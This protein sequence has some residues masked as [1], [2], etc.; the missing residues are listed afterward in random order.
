MENI[1]RLI[2]IDDNLNDAEMMISAIKSGGYA[3]RA[4][5]AEDEEDFVEALKA[6]SPDVVLLTLGTESIDLENTV[7]RIREAGKHIPVIAVSSDRSVDGVECMLQGAEDLVFKDNLEHLK[8]VVYRTF[9]SQ[10]QWRQLKKVEASLS[11][12]EKRCRIL[13]D[14]SRDSICYVHEG[15]HVYANDTY[16]NLFGYSDPDEIEGMP[17]MDMVAPDHQQTMKKF[18]RNLKKAAEENETLDIKLQHADGKTFSAQMEFSRASVDG[19]SCT[20]II[21]RDQTDAEEIQQKLNYLSQLDPTTRLFNRK[22]FMQQLE[23]AINRAKQGEENST[24]VQVDIC[25]IPEIK[26][27]VGVAHTDEVIADVAKILESYCDKQ[28]LLAKFGEDSFSILTAQSAP[29]K[30]ITQFEKMVSA[31]NNHVSNIEGRSV[32]PRVCAGAAQIDENTPDNNE[33]LLRVEKTIEQIKNKNLT[34]FA[35]YVP[36]EGEMTQKQ[37][38]SMWK[39][40]L[41]QAL[42]DGHFRLVFQPIVSLH[43]DPGERYEIYTRLLDDHNQEISASQFMPSVERTGIGTALDRW[44]I[45]NAINQLGEVRKT[46]TDTIFFVKLTVGSLQ[47]PD[48]LPW[49]AEHLRESFLS[50]PNLVFEIREEMIVNYLK[51]AKN[52]VKGL[53]ELDCKFAVEGFGTGLNSFQLLKAITVD[54]LKIDRCLM[55]NLSQNP[56]NQESVRRI[57]TTAHAENYVIIAPFV[58]DATTLT[59]LWGMGVNYIQ[60]NF[61]QE[62]SETMGYDFSTIS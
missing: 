26:E 17:L 21:I 53:H 13:L 6:H 51:P 2:V 12:T 56:E 20:Q 45:S 34:G 54:Y 31:I 7:D 32:S 22:Y 10:Q 55:E 47:D 18:L 3:V 30:L 58:E 39:S 61:L 40:R 48:L 50:P 38:D 9:K 41:E 33:L 62:A 1:V 14:S 29:K 42:Q 46:R 23:A 36:K 24:L 49:L 44:L 60:G 52:L 27:H 5:Q 57:T 43:G 35:V 4:K 8:L 37:Q 25:N 11:E 16:L 59:I 19:E 15:M 28:M